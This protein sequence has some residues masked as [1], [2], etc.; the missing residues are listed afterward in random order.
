SFR[1]FFFFFALHSSLCVGF[2]FSLLLIPSP[3]FD[4]FICQS[5]FAFRDISNPPHLLFRSPLLF[6]PL[7]SSPFC[8]FLSTPL[9][10]IR[11]AFYIPFFSRLSTSPPASRRF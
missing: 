3:P 9:S 11:G 7:L 5:V 8:H 6:S 4:F 1:F 2:F 10:G